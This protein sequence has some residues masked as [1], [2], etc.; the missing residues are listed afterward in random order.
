MTDS[1][2][3]RDAAPG[4]V[5]GYRFPADGGPA[6]E[7]ESDSGISQLVEGD[8]FVWLHFALPDRQ[9]E[10]EIQQLEFLPDDAKKILVGRDRHLLLSSMPPM[11]AGVMPDFRRELD[12]KLKDI[13]QFRFVL[14][15][16][17]I[18]TTRTSPLKSASRVRNEVVAGRVFASST[19]LFETMAD[20]FEDSIEALVDELTETIDTIEE[21]LFQGRHSRSQSGLGSVRRDIARVHRTLRTMARLFNRLDS[22]ENRGLSPELHAILEKRGHHTASLDQ[23]II[24]LQER[25]RL[26]QE[27]INAR[28]QEE[29]NRSLFVLSVVT[30]IFMP[31]TLVTGFFG[32]NTKDMFLQAEDGGTTLAL[33]I[34]IGAAVAAWLLLRRYKLDRFRD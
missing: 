23:D 31:P 19:E 33:V 14:S 27:E 11:L 7:L 25:A 1:I 24:L 12:D 16:R 10:Q 22:L 21:D 4:L 26:L 20:T 2:M 18:L 17:W 28:G 30:V 29:M 8:G 15:P 32:M 9:L 6:V 13:D 3:R 5:W 34:V